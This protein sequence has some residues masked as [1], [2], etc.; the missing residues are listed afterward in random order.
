MSIKCFVFS[1]EKGLVD[2]KQYIKKAILSVKVKFFT[3]TA[4]NQ[5]KINFLIF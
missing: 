3:Q 2:Y 4:R 1:K 5:H